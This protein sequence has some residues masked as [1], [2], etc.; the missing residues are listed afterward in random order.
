MRRSAVTLPSLALR[1]QLS[2]D[3]IS[4]FWDNSLMPPVN[5]DKPIRA[6][7]SESEYT[8]MDFMR[9]FPDDKA[10]L[11]HLWRTRF[12]P[13]GE[14]ATCPKCKAVRSFKRYE[15]AQKRPSWTCTGCGYHL[16]VLSGT[17]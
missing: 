8:L 17:I 10:C 1:W 7:A 13:D 14:H 12:A 3:C 2:L 5:R 9:D 15:T 4:G 11:E 6:K 16:H